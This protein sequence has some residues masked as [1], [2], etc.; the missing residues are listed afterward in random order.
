VIRAGLIWM[1]AVCALP[2]WAEGRNDP[3]LTCLFDAGPQ[4]VLAENG[5]SVIWI[6]GET[7][8][9]TTCTFEDAAI[10]GCFIFHP[11]RGPTTLLVGTGL[12]G[13]DAVKGQAILVQAT[14]KKTNQINAGTHRGT[15]REYLG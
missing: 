12:A 5:D 8:I 6:E 7:E 15:C 2:V 4:V 1:G 9:A 11:T 10:A 13:S 14:I 3:F